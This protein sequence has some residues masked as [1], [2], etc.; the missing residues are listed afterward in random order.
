MDNMFGLLLALGIGFVIWWWVTPVSGLGKAKQPPHRE[1]VSLLRFNPVHT[2]RV[3]LKDEAASLEDQATKIEE[4][5]VLKERILKA[6]ERI[7]EA[8]AKSGAGFQWSM[9]KTVLSLLAVVVIIL[10]VRACGNGG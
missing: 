4:E 2:S 8:R 10:A 7:S 3:S 9:G 5:A 6:K 1:P